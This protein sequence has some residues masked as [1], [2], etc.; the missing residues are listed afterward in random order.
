MTMREPRVAVVHDWLVTCHGGS[1]RVVAQILK[2]FP[3]AD[4]FTLL[5]NLPE[6]GR[7]FLDGH[8]VVTSFLNKIPGA[9]R[10]HRYLLP[11]MPCAVESLDVSSYDLILS[12]S[13]A[14][15]KGVLTGPRQ[16]HI[17]YCHSPI[18]YA[19]DLQH[20][21]FD[22][23]GLGQGPRRWLA[24]LT[25]HYLRMWDLRTVPGVDAFIANSGF[26]ARRIEKTY[27]RQSTVIHPPVNV[28]DFFLPPAKDDFYVVVARMVPYKRVGILLSAFEQLPG[29]TLMVI[30]DG[31]LL[32]ALMKRAPPN[33][34]MVGGQP[35]ESMR[36]YLQRARA[37]LY[38]AE[39]DFGIA[40]V[41][42]QACGT[43]VIAFRA[44]GALETVMD[45][46]TGVFFDE[47]SPESVVSAIQR[48]ESLESS[49]SP[50][51]IRE[52]ALRFSA[53]NF[54]AEYESFVLRHC[55]TQEFNSRLREWAESRVASAIGA[56]VSAGG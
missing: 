51:A 55:L 41:E 37:F 5:E 52:H 39:E 17:C 56:V 47:Q 27:G 3:S 43:P 22:E 44:G 13:H 36:S 11:L 8:R 12:S 6:E 31:P 40:M 49:F 10:A 34:H 2:L 54:R 23:A 19:W 9:R 48:F 42:A 16:L 25:M 15:S 1:E 26:V 18:R 46:R 30:G 7:E 32:K 35:F 24:S 53:R 50:P 4:V 14:V 20:Q 45:G 21:Y 28:D 33:V 29:R 38:A